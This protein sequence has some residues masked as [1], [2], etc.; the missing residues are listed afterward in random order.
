MPVGY[1][2]TTD[3]LEL[4]RRSLTSEGAIRITQHAR[5]RLEERDFDL[6]DV[7]KVLKSGQIYAPPELD[8]KHGNWKYRIE[9]Q[10]IDNRELIL[11]IC[12]TPDPGARVITVFPDER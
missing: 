2:S 5:E 10:S 11:V 3:A 12:F 8:V 1:L 4:A 7:R 9:G 6:H